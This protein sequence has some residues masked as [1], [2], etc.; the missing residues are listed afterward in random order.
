MESEADWPTV[1]TMMENGEWYPCFDKGG[2]TSMSK[3]DLAARLSLRK[4]LLRTRSAMTKSELY[5]V[6]ARFGEY[7]PLLAPRR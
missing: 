6:S 3:R 7:N 5:E 2:S 4:L 1:K